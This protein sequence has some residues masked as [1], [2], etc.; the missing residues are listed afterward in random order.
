M[1]ASEYRSYRNLP[2]LAGLGTLAEG[3]RLGP[4][5]DECVQ[6]LKRHHWAFRRLHEIF[7]RRLTAEPVYE[8]KMGFSLHAYYCAEH[9]AA[10]RKRVAEM[11]EPPLGLD[12]VPHEALEAFFDEI[13]NA[14]DIASLLLGVYEHA[15]PALHA[16]LKNHFETTN[17]LVDHPSR[18]ICR[19]ALIEIEEMLAFGQ[20]SISAMVDAPSRARLIPQKAAL[21]RL[22]SQAGDLDGAGQPAAGPVQRHNL[23]RPYD[24]TPRRDERFPDPYNMGVHAEKFLYD[25]T[26]PDDAKTLMMFYK[27][28]R[29][30]DVPEMMASIIAETKDKPWT[31]T[32]DMTRQLWDEARHAMMGEVGLVRAGIDW[33]KFVRINF[34][35][36]L[37]LNSQL[38]PPRA[39]CGSLFYRTGTHAQN[40]QALRMGGWQSLRRSICRPDPGLRLGGRGAACTDRA[41]LVCEGDGRSPQG[42]RIWG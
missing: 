15:L 39:P 22:L 18:R 42:C 29:E 20:R 11:R 34:T 36:S 4:G 10:W 2:P 1:N 12:V 38:S 13:L 16:A 9:A 40:R 21:D 33:Q 7:I 3:M 19:F 30:I 27:R 8:L 6:K 31:Y 37:A 41:R 28:L 23:P 17:V 24:S 35:W 14:P 26:M 5:I 32:V 25:P